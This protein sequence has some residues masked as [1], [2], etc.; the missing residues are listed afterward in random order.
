MNFITVSDME[1]LREGDF[2]LSFAGTCG[3]S[4]AASKGGQEVGTGFRAGELDGT[5]S[6]GIAA[7]PFGDAS[8]LAD[9]VEED[10][11]VQASSQVMGIKAAV[12]FVAGKGL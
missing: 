8:G 1:H 7:E 2:T 4:V 3:N 6:V 10:F 9:G 12:I 5:N 11:G